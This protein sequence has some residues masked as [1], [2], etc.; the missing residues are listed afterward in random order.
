[1]SR[2]K[3]KNDLMLYAG[4]AA[5][6]LILTNKKAVSGI[7]AANKEELELILEYLNTQLP[8]KLTFGYAYGKQILR[9]SDGSK[10]YSGYLNKKEME[11]FLRGMEK[12]IDIIKY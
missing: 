3:G 4:I 2:R 11:I 10:E 5:A 7:G 1:M 8:K 6:A 12:A 9:S